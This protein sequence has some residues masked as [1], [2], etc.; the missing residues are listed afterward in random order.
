MVP[1]SDHLAN[2][3]FDKK[4][5]A[6]RQAVPGVWL[7]V[8]G[9]EGERTRAVRRGRDAAVEPAGVLQGGIKNEML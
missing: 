2:P 3:R 7:A 4:P 5:S 6:Q 9:P 8:R 1:K